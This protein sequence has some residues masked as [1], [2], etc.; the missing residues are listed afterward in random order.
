[1]VM[2]IKM[3]LMNGK[4]VY[5]IFLEKYKDKLQVFTPLEFKNLNSIYKNLKYDKQTK[6]NI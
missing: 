2:D 1:M 3:V 5:H 4:D 6:I